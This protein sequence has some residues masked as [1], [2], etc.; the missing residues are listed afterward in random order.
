MSSRCLPIG[1][2]RGSGALEGGQT[3]VVGLEGDSM[4]GPDEASVLGPGWCWHSVVR[5]RD[6]RAA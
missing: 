5:S 2:W 4:G 3:R 1:V 6:G